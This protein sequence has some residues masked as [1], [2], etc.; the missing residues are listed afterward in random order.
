MTHTQA[1]ETHAVE[2]YL[3]G[4]LSAGDRDAFEIHY[5]ECQACAEDLRVA[6]LMRD[7][8][9][10]GLLDAPAAGRAPVPGT[11]SPFR[12]RRM[13]PPSVA[14][15]WAVAATLAL[16]TGYQALWL[17][18][19]LRQQALAPHALSPVT[20]RPASRGAE[21]VVSRPASG[22][23]TLAVE[24]AGLPAGEALE[25]DL[26]TP[27]GRSAASGAV[28]APSPGAPLLLL[29]PAPSFATEGIYVLQFRTD[30][31]GPPTAEYRFRVTHQ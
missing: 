23:V 29:I 31:D 10:A 26:R 15:P 20:L 1:I 3:L 5:F 18:P 4:E 12:P 11:V 13:W 30:T 17:V 16:A 7:G 8:A 9:A 27:D 21:P 19:E 6:A 22:P 14:L 25:Y 24:L 28:A 2:R